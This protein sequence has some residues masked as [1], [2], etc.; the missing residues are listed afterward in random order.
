MCVCVCVCVC[1]LRTWR[2]VDVAVCMFVGIIAHA[3]FGVCVCMC[4]CSN[5]AVGC[6]E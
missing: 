2:G 3:I 1:V 4:V 6:V 5:K